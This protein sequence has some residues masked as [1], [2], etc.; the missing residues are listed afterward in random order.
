MDQAGF[1]CK[2]YQRGQLLCTKQGPDLPTER[3][4][5]P[6]DL[7]VWGFAATTEVSAV[8]VHDTFCRRILV[9]HLQQSQCRLQNQPSLLWLSNDQIWWHGIVQNIR[10]TRRLYCVEWTQH[11]IR[12]KRSAMCNRSFPGPTRVLNANGISIASEF[13]AR[14]TRWQTDR[15][16]DRPRYLLVHN[17]RHL[18]T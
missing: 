18:P 1:W 11:S 8:R 3:K 17:R 7:W 12:Q 6:T 16:T 14:L 9:S 10:E 2:C 13:S 5:S 15:Q 4:T